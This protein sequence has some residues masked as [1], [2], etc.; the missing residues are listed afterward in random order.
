MSDLKK[1]VQKRKKR[2]AE[3][4][5]GYDE[6]R[7]ELRIGL[8]LKSAREKRGMTQEELARRVRTTKSAISR[9]ENHSEDMKL[10]TLQKVAAALGKK[11]SIKI[12]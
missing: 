8:V 9:I 2:D 5:A 11:L 10:S 12:I 7:E 4:A 6:G 3:F 1:Y